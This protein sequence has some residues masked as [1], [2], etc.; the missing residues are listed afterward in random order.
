MTPARRITPGA[1]ARRALA[2]DALAALVLA[3]LLLQLAAGLGVVAA[4]ALPLL[5]LGLLWLGAERLLAR[6]RPRRLPA[7]RPA[8]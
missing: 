1:R 5:L 8:R 6:L 7:A 2:L 4:V 3:L